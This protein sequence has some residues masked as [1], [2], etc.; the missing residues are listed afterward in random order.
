MNPGV[1]GV[2]G[3]DSDRPFP[4]HR[5]TLYNAR[6]RLMN[7]GEIVRSKGPVSTLYTT[8]AT[9]KAAP[10]RMIEYL[11]GLPTKGVKGAFWVGNIPDMDVI[12]TVALFDD[13]ASSLRYGESLNLARKRWNLKARKVA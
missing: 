9:A 3:M 4:G 2:P 1:I 13:A 8:A 12:G 10:G 7:R 5:D 11:R 6:A